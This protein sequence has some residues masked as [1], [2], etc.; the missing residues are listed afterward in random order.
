MNVISLVDHDTVVAIKVQSQSEDAARMVLEQM[1]LT[2]LIGTRHSP[3]LYCS[4]ATNGY[5]YIVMQMLGRNLTE[6][7][8]MQKDRKFTV[9]T[10]VRIGIQTIDALRTVHELGYIHRDIKPS[11]MCVGLGEH[12]R[13]IYVVDFGMARQYRRPNGQWRRERKYVAFR[14]TMRY[15]SLAVHERREQKFSSSMPHHFE[16]F[17][18]L[19]SDIQ[20]FN[21]PDYNKLSATLKVIQNKVPTVKM[22]TK[23]MDKCCKSV[24]EDADFE[25]NGESST[26]SY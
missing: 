22:K 23:A 20:Y 11:N 2:Q 26:Q 15:V 7:R 24:D 25:W 16:M 19:L 18:I 4:G 14:G 21:V 6:L 13:I 5:N 10:T 3:R 12:R 17:P 8:K 9:H 1:V